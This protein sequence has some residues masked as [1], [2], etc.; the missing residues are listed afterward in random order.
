M[1]RENGT[2]PN[3][4]LARFVS[5]AG[6]ATYHPYPIPSLHPPPPSKI[7]VYVCVIVYAYSALT[8]A[9]HSGLWARL[10]VKQAGKDR[11]AVCAVGD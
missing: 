10:S 11:A 7:V 1:Q 2:K 8:F 4:Y 3:K 5:Q 9:A 6:Q